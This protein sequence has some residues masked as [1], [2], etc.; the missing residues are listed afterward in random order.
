MMVEVVIASRLSDKSSDIVAEMFPAEHYAVVMDVNTAKALGNKVAHALG[1][2]ATTIMLGG[3]P[4]ASMENVEK[5]RISSQHADALIAIG[6]GTINDLCKYT[7]FLDEKSYGVWATAPSMNGYTSANASI[8]VDGHKTTLVAHAPQTVWAD[9]DVMCNAPLRLIQ[10]GL[11]DSLCRPTAQFDWLLSH[12][13]LG[14]PYSTEPFEMLKPY[15]TELFAQ[16]DKLIARDPT[17]IELLIKTLIASGDGMRHSGGSH[18][19][20]QAEHMIAHTLEMMVPSS[21]ASHYH[22]EE[23]AVTTLLTA[24]MQHEWMSQKKPPIFTPKPF[25]LEH[26]KQYFS[27][28]Q[29]AAFEKESAAKQSAITAAKIHEKMSTHWD[30]I[31]KQL[32]SVML[33]FEVLEETLT[34]AQMHTTPEAL[35]W[36][37]RILPAMQSAPFT[38][39]RFTI[40]DLA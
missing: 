13:L 18:P 20:S 24:H 16:S 28:A 3:T 7:S 25:P 33:T 6:S 23:I 14:T 21:P 22:G 34:N 9:V 40:M 12:L 32:S 38:R 15:E 11:G 30:D 4:S 17:I 8:N 31:R 19:A 27:D 2:K 35:G 5:L 29:C 37:E 26:M 1:N 39:N 10:S 36:G